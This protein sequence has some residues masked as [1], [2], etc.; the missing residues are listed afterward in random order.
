MWYT[1]DIYSALLSGFQHVEGNAV[2]IGSI[3]MGGQTYNYA[4]AYIRLSLC[5]EIH[6]L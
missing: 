2:L 5:N 4:G 6:P 3:I 1:H